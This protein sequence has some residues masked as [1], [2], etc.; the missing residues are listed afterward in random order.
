MEDAHICQP[1]IAVCLKD[2]NTSSSSA[3]VTTENSELTKEA[4]VDEG[5]IILK[6]HSLFAVFDGHGGSLAAEFA[7]KQFVRILTQ[8][9]KF[10]EY[11]KMVA[12]ESNQTSGENPKSEQEEYTHKTK[13][14]SLLEGSLRDAFYAVDKELGSTYGIRPDSMHTD[15]DGNAMDTNADDSDDQIMDESGT[16]AVVVLITPTQII[17]ANAGDSRSVYSKSKGRTIPLSYDHK[18]SDEYEENRIV[19]AGGYVSG[20]RVDGDLAV[21]RGLGDFRFKSGAHLSA[22][23]QKVTA[24]PDIIVQNRIDEE[25]EF[26]LVACDG[27]WDVMTNNEAV[28]MVHQML[29]E[30]EKSMGLICEESLDLCL[31]KGSKDNMTMLVVKLPGL[32][33]NGVGGGVT[34]RRQER[35]REAQEIR[36]AKESLRNGE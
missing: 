4:T 27:I 20:N 23:F 14:L 6:D 31:A 5:F 32:K 12:A 13:L 22:E 16:T 18:P 21:S 3:P 28:Q 29:H 35:E 1:E 7:G 24:M 34:A 25:D 19:S 10:K 11:A 9:D 17:C 2:K 8:Q 26:I 33:M 15:E 36:S 30:G